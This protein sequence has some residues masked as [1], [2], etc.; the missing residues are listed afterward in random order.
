MVWQNSN[1]SRKTSTFKSA[2][3]FRYIV[4]LDGIS[5]VYLKGLS[6][7]LRNVSTVSIVHAALG[8]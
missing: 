2:S 7:P 6:T 3:G 4:L 8:G 5:I 1:L